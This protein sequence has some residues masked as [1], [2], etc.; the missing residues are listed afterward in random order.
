MPKSLT[1]PMMLYRTR[2]LYNL[3]THSARRVTDLRASSGF[4]FIYFCDR[5]HRINLLILWISPVVVSAGS[6]F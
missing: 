2:V 1:G 5:E 6:F 4:L 3:F